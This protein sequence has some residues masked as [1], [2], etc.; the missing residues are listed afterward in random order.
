MDPDEL[1]KRADAM[2]AVK[3][4]TKVGI[5]LAA[6]GTGAM[7][8]TAI[9][10]PVGTVAGAAIGIGISVV[11]SV[12]FDF[13]GGKS[14]K[15]ALADLAMT[16]VDDFMESDLMKSDAGKAARKA[17]DSVAEAAGDCWN[18]LFGK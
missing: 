17:A 13:L 6:A 5:D 3:G 11:T 2:G 7:I 1:D 12:E 15:D 10:G 14:V 16:G 9:G 4:G 18:K 8:G